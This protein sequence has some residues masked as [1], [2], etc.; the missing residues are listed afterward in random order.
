MTEPRNPGT[1]PDDTS[2]WAP[3]STPAAAGPVA[4]PTQHGEPPMPGYEPAE[5]GTSAPAQTVA[6]EDA[7]G[8]GG[9]GSRRRNGIRWA[10]ALIGVA[11]V[12]GATAAIVALASGRPQASIAVGYMP[13]QVVQ[14][15]EYRLDLPGDQRQKLAGFLSAFPGFADQAAI[16]TKL[17]ETF[18]RIIRAISNDE[19]SWTT[20]IEP[21]FGGIVA[22][23]SG[24]AQVGDGTPGMSAFG[25]QPLLVVS[26]KDRGLASAWIQ[27]LSAE[28]LTLSRA[29]YNGADFFSGQATDAGPGYA[30]AINDEVMLVG[31]KES[32][33]DAVDSNGDGTLANDTEFKAALGTVDKDYVLFQF[34]DIKALANS[35]VEVL[36]QTD[37]GANV[38][39]IADTVVGMIPAWNVV[40][41]RFENDAFTTAV[42]SPAVD[43]GVN[44]TNKPSA[45]LGFAPP[46]TIAYYEVHD[47]GATVTAII[48]RLRQIPEARDGIAEVEQTT[49]Q[50]VADVFGWWGDASVAISRDGA[51]NLGGGLLIQPKDA[52]AATHL[53]D[54]LRGLVVL[55]GGQAGFEVRDV[56][57]GSA[58]I[59]VIDFSK[60]L[61]GDAS[62]LPEGLKPELAY[63][64]TDQ[65]VV[66][67]VGQA[68]VE[69]A[70][71]AGP[72]PSLA[73]DSRVSSL[74]DRVGDENLGFT[75]VDVRAVRELLEP[76]LE[77]E[78]T[79]EQWTNYEKEIKPFLVPFDAAVSSTRDDG[80]L[81][82]G[83]SVITVTKP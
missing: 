69:S 58:T 12:V 32:V 49:G 61:A 23:G 38:S 79:P 60:A 11:L 68:F 48:D 18:D 64:V 52:A 31:T 21:W 76:F 37:A 54:V 10:I 13:N 44:T 65:V 59:T 67:G 17:D 2:Q 57:H 71:D 40:V 78:M 63:T 50:T 35:Y 56:P 81:D 53:F 75:F 26:I 46:G 72:G 25:G 55:A 27:N 34:Q 82:R 8:A 30:I 3:P 33:Q 73:D 42:A 45:L 66:I 24:P 29:E 74:L 4:A 47:V 9:S 62:V 41:G 39:T 83:S 22:M 14:Y 28:H 43:I 15:G 5:P 70:L 7:A 51:G 77:S 36:D 80:D 1:P 16:D 20:D 6:R 19:Q